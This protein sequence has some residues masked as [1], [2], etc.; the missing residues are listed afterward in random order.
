MPRKSTL[1]FVEEMPAICNIEAGNT[2]TTDRFWHP[3]TETEFVSA[4]KNSVGPTTYQMPPCCCI[5]QMLVPSSYM[6]VVYS[7]KPCNKFDE[8][9]R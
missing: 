2:I 9:V 5:N 3:Q 6:Q 1:K 4:V 7:C 8:V